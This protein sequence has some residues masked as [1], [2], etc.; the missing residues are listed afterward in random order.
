MGAIFEEISTFL[1]MQ[2][3][4]AAVVALGGS[5]AVSIFLFMYKILKGSGNIFGTVDLG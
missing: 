5:C 4:M 3:G 1:S 2:R